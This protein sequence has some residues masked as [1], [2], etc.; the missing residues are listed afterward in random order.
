MPLPGFP[1]IRLTDELREYAAGP[2]FA[3]PL[4]AQHAA[5]AGGR[6]RADRLGEPALWAP[7]RRGPGRQD[8]FPASRRM[9]RG[10]HGRHHG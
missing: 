10:R 7:G 3:G 6:A 8:D 9:L 4:I 5:A 1:D 2:A